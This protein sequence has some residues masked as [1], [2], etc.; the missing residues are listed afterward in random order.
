MSTVEKR[1]VSLPAEVVAEARVAAK[2]AG[3]TLSAWLAAAAE[4]R[5][6]L[7]ALDE[8]IGA[9]EAECGPITEAELAEVRAKFPNLR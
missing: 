2:A 1:S 9:Y 7:Q 5:L 4:Y 6:K 8:A 3:M